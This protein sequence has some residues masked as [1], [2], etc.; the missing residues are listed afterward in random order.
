MMAI[1]TVVGPHPSQLRDLA[2]SLLVAAPSLFDDPLSRDFLLQADQ[3][4]SA[5]YEAVRAQSGAPT[6]RA[7]QP[8]TRRIQ[9]GL[10]SRCWPGS[11]PTT[12]SGSR[13]PTPPSTTTR[14]VRALAADAALRRPA[15]CPG[16]RTPPRSGHPARSGRRR[17]RP[18]PAQRLREP[19]SS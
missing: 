17:T 6:G 9:A 2:S 15:P 12:S 16:S 7:G 8:L 3:L 11:R 5:L 19:G 14:A 18:R 10:L 4:M 1:A 13:T